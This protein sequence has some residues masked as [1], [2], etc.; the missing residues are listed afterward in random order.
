MADLK[1]G[2]LALDMIKAEAKREV[3]SNDKSHAAGQGAAGTS[4]QDSKN[5]NREILGKI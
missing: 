3:L 5:L 2:V 1:R 4:S